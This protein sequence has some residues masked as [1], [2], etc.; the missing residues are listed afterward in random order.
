MAKMWAQTARKNPGLH[1]WRAGTNLAVDLR[2]V[3]GSSAGA[4]RQA[5]EWV[6]FEYDFEPLMPQPVGMM[7]FDFDEQGRPGNWERHERF[8]ERDAAGNFPEGVWFTEGTSRVLLKDPRAATQIRLK[9]HLISQARYRPSELFLWVPGSGWSRRVRM[10]PNPNYDALGPVFDFALEPQER[11]FF[12]LKFVR[13]EGDAFSAFEPDFANRLWSADDGAEIWT[14]SEAAEITPSQPA[15]KRLTVHFRQEFTARPELH[16]WQ[17]NSD[18]ITDL[19]AAAEENGWWKFETQLYTNMR[20]GFLARNDELGANEWE[21]R[22]A[23]R[24]LQIRTDRSIWALEGSRVT[25]S[26]E[27]RADAEANLTVAVRPPFSQLAGDLTAEVRVDRARETLWDV[28]VQANGSVLIQGYRNVRTVVR[29]RDAHGRIEQIEGHPIVLG[30]TRQ[31]RFVVLERPPLLENSPPPGFFEDPPFPIRRPG[32][33]EES[34][35]VHFVLH[36]PAAS[37]MDLVA[38]WTNWRQQAVAMKSTRDGAYWWARIRKSELL[39]QL[40]RAH[41]HGAKYR[42]LFNETTELQD[43][44]AGW[45]ESSWSGASSQLIDPSRFA[46]QDAG[47][48]R[49]GFDYYSVYQLHPARFSARHPEAEPLRQVAREFESHAG[50]LRD[51]GITAIL[52]MPLNEV[53]SNNGWGYDPA[54]FYAIERSYG[55]PDALKELVNTCHRHGIAVLV[56]VVFNHAG[57]IDNILWSVARESFFDGDTAWGSMINFDH[58][59]CRHFFEQNLVYLAREFHIDGFRLDHTYTIIHSHEQNWYVRVPGTGGG[60]EFMHGLRHAV[61]SQVDARVL[62]MAEH[63]PN[64]WALTNFGGPMD[65]QWCDAFHDRLIEACKG[66]RVM[67]ALAEA[68]QVTHRESDDWYKGTNYPESHD[69][70]GNV[71]DRVTFVAGWGRGLRMSKVAAAASI[72]AR[73]IPMFFMGAEGGED[74][75]FMNGSTGRLDL[76]RYLNDASRRKVRDWWKEMLRLRRNPVVTGPSP[77][78]VT[79]GEGQ[80]LAFTRGNGGEMFVVLNFGGWAGSKPLAELNLPDGVYC[81]LWNSTWPAFSIEAEDEDEHMNWGREA[82]L[83]RGNWLHV[84]DYGVVVL[85]RVG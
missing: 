34:G 25:F 20:Y 29:F 39:Q 45:V 63:L 55:G 37:R 43:P 28:P 48:E 26:H 2:P 44:A 78:A 75:Q 27:P 6:A 68:M 69:E 18:Y 53:G 21:H 52:L 22:E 1:V 51:L 7:L 35:F 85:S 16:L 65:T 80:M 23:A 66:A 57:N 74:A 15:R 84:P 30:D 81:E 46:W 47:W 67:S 38:E 62:L 17:L 42:F 70:V 13:K 9:V 61:H 64:E 31:Q 5:G 24:E 41:Y 50:Y 8:F 33:Y 54:F 72:L 77:L 4:S 71:R 83:T 73:G 79:F 14:H 11:S 76:A 59:Q 32:A 60:W 82:R 49:P 58:P 56:D 10:E 40:H 36:A 3:G 19:S 12:N